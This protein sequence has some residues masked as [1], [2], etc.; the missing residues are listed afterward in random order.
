MQT[1][2]N[3]IRKWSGL[4]AS[5]TCLYVLGGCASAGFSKFDE[6]K[7]PKPEPLVLREGD[8]VRI[9]FPGA[10]NLNIVEQIKR[11]GKIALQ[12]V[13]EVQAAGLTAKQLENE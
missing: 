5:L 8:S 12:L 3:S 1:H 9:T 7:L 10:P 11:D 6:D 4:F 13:G 2:S